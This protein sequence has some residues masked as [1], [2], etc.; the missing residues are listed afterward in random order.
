MSEAYTLGQFRPSVL[1]SEIIE[2]EIRSFLPPCC[3]C[4]RVSVRVPMGIEP[5]PDNLEWHQDGGGVA[6]TT[7]HM[8]VWATEMPTELKSSSGELFEFKPF[9]LIWFNND[10]AFHRQP[11]DTRPSE[12]WFVSIRCSGEII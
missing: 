8:V 5:H 1:Q 3:K 12:R 11:R 9:D 10:K 7:R 2:V 6:G 4:E